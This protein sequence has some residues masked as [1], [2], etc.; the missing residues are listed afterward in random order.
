MSAAV[1]RARPRRRGLRHQ[2][3]RRADRAAPADP[4]RLRAD[5]PDRAR[6]HRRRRAALLPPRPRAAAPDR[7]PHQRRH[8]HR[9]RAPDHGARAPGR[10]APRPQR[11]AA[12]PSSTPYA[13][14]SRRAAAA[15]APSRPT[16]CRCSTRPSASPIVV[17]R[18]GALTCLASTAPPPTSP[19]RRRRST[20]PSSTP[21]R[22]LRGCRRT[23]CAASCPTRACARAAASR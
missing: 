8:R 16:S 19:R 7:R 18:R 3:R 22:S 23:A 12:S 10:R 5:G 9:G 4:A 15:G 20:P 1:R 21:T 14:G 13:A 6:S 17:W 2:R 11:G